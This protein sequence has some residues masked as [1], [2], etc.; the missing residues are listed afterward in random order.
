MGKLLHL[1]L[2][3]LCCCSFNIFL[4]HLFLRSFLIFMFMPI[5]ITHTASKHVYKTY[6]S[7]RWMFF[8]FL[9][10]WRMH[11]SEKAIFF[12]HMY[13]CCL[14][15]R[16]YLLLYMTETLYGWYTWNQRIYFLFWILDWR[17]LKGKDFI[18]A[19]YLN[20][21]WWNLGFILA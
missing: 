10:N 9:W 7:T 2:F 1:M 12:T 19:E 20:K 4:F 15:E 3:I 5:L 14:D 16:K 11:E 21:Y 17:V 18:H 8:L 13:F 6:V